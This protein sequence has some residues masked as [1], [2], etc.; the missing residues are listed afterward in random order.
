[1]ADQI[2][3]GLMEKFAKKGGRYPGMDIPEFYELTSELF[4]PEE[5][6][7]AAAMP[8]GF[9]TAKQLHRGGERAR[10]RSSALCRR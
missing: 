6:S 10:R 7:V 5:A 9:C 3:K 8:K 2:Y 1:M 4:T